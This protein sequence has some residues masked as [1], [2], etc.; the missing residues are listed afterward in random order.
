MLISTYA[1]RLYF[2]YICVSYNR[3]PHIDCACACC[4]FNIIQLPQDHTKSKYPVL[5]VFK[6]FKGLSFFMASECK[7]PP[8]RPV[9][10]IYSA[11]S[12]SSVRYYI[13]IPAHLYFF[14]KK[15]VDYASPVYITA[16][17][18]HYTALLQFTHNINRCFIVR[19]SP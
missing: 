6:A 11:Q 4:I 2:R 16:Y 5:A 9:Q 19:R 17:K 13:G 14:F 12:I 8:Y 15:L 10:R 1:A 18:C 3:K 7:R